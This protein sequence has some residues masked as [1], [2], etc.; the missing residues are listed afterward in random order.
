M[1]RYPKKDTPEFLEAFAKAYRE[2]KC[3]LMTTSRLMGISY[4]T[5]IKYRN[6]HP[7]FNAILDE[8]EK[9]L[10]ERVEGGLVDEALKDG[11]QIVAKIFY[12]KN[13]WREKYAERTEVNVQPG[14]LWFEKQDAIEGETVEPK[15]LES[16]E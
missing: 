14:A 16:P 9:E 7:D 4:V 10:A 15:Q 3:Q 13:N 8:H 11:G 6:L 2:N 1:P 12:L 5:A